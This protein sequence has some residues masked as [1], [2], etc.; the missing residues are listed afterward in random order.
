MGFHHDDRIYKVSR[1]KNALEYL[2]ISAFLDV[3]VLEDGLQRTAVERRLLH[4]ARWT[5]RIKRWL[6]S[7]YSICLRS[8]SAARGS[9]DRKDG[10]DRCLCIQDS[11]GPSPKVRRSEETEVVLRRN[12]KTHTMQGCI[13]MN[14]GRIHPASLQ[15]RHPWGRCDFHT[16]AV[17]Q[18]FAN[19]G[20]L[21]SSATSRSLAQ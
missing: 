8:N 11:E 4:R 20:D 15:K 16:Q 7:A 5:E 21:K 9:R 1:R 10:Q 2:G 12:N 17:Q 13:C 19:L 18:R 3:I 6:P 14:Y